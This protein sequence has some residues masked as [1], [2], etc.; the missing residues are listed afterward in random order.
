MMIKRLRNEKKIDNTIS[1]EAKLLLKKSSNQKATFTSWLQTA[2]NKASVE[3]EV[4]KFMIYVSAGWITTILFT[5]LLTRSLLSSIIV[6]VLFPLSVH[7]FLS[8]LARKK[9]ESLSRQLPDVVNF[10]CSSLQ[11]GYSFQHALKIVAD[12]APAPMKRELQ[13]VF[14]DIQLGKSYEDSFYLFYQRNPTED[15]ETF[16]TA[17]MISK[18]TGGNLIKILQTLAET[19]VEKQ[20]IKGEIKSLSAQGKMSGMILVL[21]PIVIFI[22]LYVMNPTYISILLTHSLGQQ[23]LLAGVVSQIIGA[24]LIKRIVSL[25][26]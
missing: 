5:V 2:L 23:L 6:T 25:N 26:W 20:R 3:I 17:I 16:T 15:V 4:T 13:L 19:M 18:E 10:L 22:F 21:L 11:S 1:K 8:Y 7:I 9:I 12:E 14:Q 24:L